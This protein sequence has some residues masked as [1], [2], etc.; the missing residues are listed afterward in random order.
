MGISVVLFV[1]FLLSGEA[2]FWM[3]RLARKRAGGTKSQLDLMQAA[4]LGSVALLIGFTFSM[5]VYRFDNRKDR[6]VEEANAIEATYM[7]TSLL[8]RALRPEMVGHLRAYV[9]LRLETAH[10]DLPPAAR[11]ELEARTEELQQRMW[12]VGVRAS[13]ADPRS[14][15]T[16]LFNQSLN[17]TIDAYG[18]RVAALRNHVP[19]AVLLM[20]W[21]VTC[22]AV[23]FVGYTCGI[24]GHRA[25]AA[26][27][28]FSAVT[29]LVLMLIVDLDRP[30]RGLIQISQQSLREAKHLV[31]QPLP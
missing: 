31:D 25:L 16:G 23:G 27:L 8:P 13:E 4:I 14:V 20:L 22:F 17:A 29:A 19:E 26:L 15:A 18:K 2:G 12:A 21:I 11:S 9:D 10:A 30:Y 1:S 7:R 28:T 3:G 5:A 24:D 6:L